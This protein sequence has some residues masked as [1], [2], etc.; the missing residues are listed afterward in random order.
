MKEDHDM[1]SNTIENSKKSDHQEQSS[2]AN[3]RAS[4]LESKRTGLVGRFLNYLS[5]LFWVFL[6]TGKAIPQLS[7]Q[8][9]GSKARLWKI[10]LAVSLIFVAERLIYQHFSG[11]EHQIGP[12]MF[13]IYTPF[14]WVM[15][16][17]IAWLIRSFGRIL[18]GKIEK[19]QA[20]LAIA[21]LLNIQV[22]LIALSKIIIF[23]TTLS[24]GEMPESKELAKQWLAT[25]MN[26][27]D[28]L[29]LSFAIFYAVMVW[30][31]IMMI[32]G[33]K[34]LFNFKLFK[35]I[36]LILLTGLSVLIILGIPL[37]VSTGLVE[38]GVI[39]NPG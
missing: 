20:R 31:M 30:N 3:S 38:M 28:T 33:I 37:F 34:N 22:L 36:F 14:V 39:S 26:E 2:S 7:N 16:V 8:T 11:H 29:G 17:M 23:F 13:L 15:I 32:S 6:S 4:Q 10:S 21:W 18:G 19:N 9:D 35:T 12:L 27:S 24:L 5:C 1:D 25:Q